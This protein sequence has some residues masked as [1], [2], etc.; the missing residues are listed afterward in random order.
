MHIARRKKLTRSA[1]RVPGRGH[2]IPT[3][4]DGS[5]GSVRGLNATPSYLVHIIIHPSPYLL[6]PHTPTN[7]HTLGDPT[8][9]AMSYQCAFFC[10]IRNSRGGH[11]QL[12]R[13]RESGDDDDVQ[14]SGTQ[15]PG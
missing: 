11:S 7:T 10:V 3:L 4:T 15:V 13:A 2:G 1:Q 9:H 5:D 8:T 12:D 6:V 14:Q